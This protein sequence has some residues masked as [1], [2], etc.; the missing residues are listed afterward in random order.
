MKRLSL[1]PANKKDLADFERRMVVYISSAFLIYLIL[2][3]GEWGDKA[4]LVQAFSSMVLIWATYQ[5]IRRSDEQI[6][7]A[8]KQIKVAVEDHSRHNLIVEQ[9]SELY[10][11]KLI[12]LSAGYI[13]I[14]RVT[15]WENEVVF[16]IPFVSEVIPPGGI[17]AFSIL[18]VNGLG[19][20]TSFGTELPIMIADPLDE[21]TFPIGLELEYFYSH[22]GD[23]VYKAEYKFSL[24]HI[25]FD[26]KR[27]YTPSI[28]PTERVI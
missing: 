12:N 27:L 1:F 8:N 19:I 2:S 26:N 16:Y 11:L 7:A 22:T 6:E 28:K 9:T 18:D 23:K 17:K 3:S 5:S 13:Y 10:F 15:T 20:P 24:E 14:R 4:T 25:D 21:V